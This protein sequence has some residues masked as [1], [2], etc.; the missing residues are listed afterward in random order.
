MY[1]QDMDSDSS[2]GE[3]Q[4]RRKKRFDRYVNRPSTLTERGYGCVA[5]DHPTD[6]INVGHALRGAL[7]FGARMVIIGG[8]P[9]G[10]DV[11]KLATDPGRAYRHVPVIQVENLFE[12]MPED[13]TPVAVELTDDAADLPGFVHPERACYVFGPES[14]S[15]TP[16]VLDRCRYRVKIPTTV[17]LNL[18]V[19]VNIVLYDRLAKNTRAAA[20][21]LP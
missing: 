16:E 5:L 2:N 14:G 19:T 1:G 6:G 4:T 17:S 13:C 21:E 12:A 8:G 9:A 15:I 11:K 3:S 18:G 7:C 10:L 20:T